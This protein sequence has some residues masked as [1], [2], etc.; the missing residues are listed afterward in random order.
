MHSCNLTWTNLMDCLDPY[1]VSANQ[2]EEARTM[3]E[4][5]QVFPRKLT[6]LIVTAILAMCLCKFKDLEQGYGDTKCQISEKFVV[7]PAE[8]A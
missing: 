2:Y 6:A 7:H 5:A 8:L 3:W 1:S 4:Q